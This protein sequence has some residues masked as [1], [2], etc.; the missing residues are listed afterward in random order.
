LGFRTNFENLIN[1][2]ITAYR[3]DFSNQIIPVSESSDGLGTDAAY[4]NGGATRHQGIETSIAFNISNM[5]ESAYLINLTTTLNYG[6]S[7]YTSDRFI[8]VSADERVNIIGN[9]LPYAPKLTFSTGL[10]ISA[11]FGT[12][13]YISGKYHGKQFTDELNSINPSANGRAGLIDEKIIF[14]STIEHK[15]NNLGITL[16]V[17]IKNIFDERY[18][19]SRRPQGIK[20]GLPRMILGGIDFN[21]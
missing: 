2:E 17:S 16:F 4:A 11:P 21:L 6:K 15:L 5:L 19:S 12:T 18:I 3:L 9:E 8:S 1:L 14:N 7:E 20:V 13:L 10:I